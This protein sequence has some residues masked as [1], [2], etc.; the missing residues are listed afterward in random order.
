MHDNEIVTDVSLVDELVR[1]QF[2]RWQGLPIR[3]VE[4]GGTDHAIYRLGEELAVR[5]PRIEGAKDHVARDAVVLPRFA[6]LLPVAVPELLAVGEPAGNYP[7]RW[8]VVRWLGGDIAPVEAVAGD[9]GIRLAELVQAVQKIDASGEPWTTYRGRL[10]LSSGDDHVR[11]SIAEL[12]GDPRLTALW[13][14]ALS[15]PRWSE[16]GRWLHADLHQGNLLFTDGELTG[17]IDWGSAGVGDPAADLMTAWLYL[18]E[19]GRK[20]FRRELGE[21]DD[22]TWVRA[23]GWAMH[24]AVLALPYYRVTNPFLADVATHTLEQL[25]TERAG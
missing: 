21:F 15:A 18:D 14:E 10:D 20:A 6:P 7:Y 17:V 24:L 8:S 2:P 11:R 3:H 23:R 22:A 4:H 16:A 12:G 25:L 19:R 9:V 1:T 5:L 13:E